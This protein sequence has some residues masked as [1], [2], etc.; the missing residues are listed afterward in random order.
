MRAA[1]PWLP[2]APLVP[3]DGA[4]LAALDMAAELGGGI[5]IRYDS[6]DAEVA[7]AVREAGVVLRAWTVDDPEEMR[8]LL[9]LG[10]DAIVTNAPDV[11][12]DA[13]RAAQPGSA[14]TRST[15]RAAARPSSR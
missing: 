13:V 9:A 3:R 8:R 14:N 1:A 2:L 5:G 12:L 11:A 10:V 7:R 15:T 4:P 6:V